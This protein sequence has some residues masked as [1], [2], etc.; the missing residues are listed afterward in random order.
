[1][2]VDIETDILSEKYFLYQAIEDF[3]ITGIN[4]SFWNG[5]HD[6][7]LQTRFIFH[8]NYDNIEM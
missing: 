5:S 6:I 8:K 3:L 1:M 7:P 4:G 2:A